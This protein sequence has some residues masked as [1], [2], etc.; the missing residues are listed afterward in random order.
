[1]LCRGLRPSPSRIRIE[2]SKDLERDPEAD[3]EMEALQETIRVLGTG[4][5]GKGKRNGKDDHKK[6]MT[7]DELE[8]YLAEGREVHM[9]LPSRR[10]LIRRLE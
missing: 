6:V 10:A 5:K 4:G 1:M 9:V 3:E 7:E 8:S 2:K